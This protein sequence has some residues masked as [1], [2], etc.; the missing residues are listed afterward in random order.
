MCVST[1]LDHNPWVYTLSPES[2][3][4]HPVGFSLM[5]VPPSSK[6]IQDATCSRECWSRYCLIKGSTSGPLGKALKDSRPTSAKR[7]WTTAMVYG[8]R[9]SSWWLMV[10]CWL[11]EGW[12]INDDSWMVDGCY[13][14]IIMV[15]HVCFNTNDTSLE[16]LLLVERHVVTRTAHTQDRTN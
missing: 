11:M 12:L 14:L 7:R 13:L 2:D 6:M 5:G 10:Q 4:R 15:A 1:K 16:A 8:W 3:H 9:F